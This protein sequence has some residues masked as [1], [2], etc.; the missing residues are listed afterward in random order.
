ME[1]ESPRNFAWMIQSINQELED[2]GNWIRICDMFRCNRCLLL[3]TKWA[4]FCWKYFSGVTVLAV[5]CN[6]CVVQAFH[7][8]NLPIHTGN[9]PLPRSAHMRF[10]CNNYVLTKQTEEK[11]FCPYNILHCLS[12]VTILA[13]RCDYFVCQMWP[14]CLSDVTILAVKMTVLAVKCDCFGCHMWLFWLS[15]MTIL[16]VSSAASLLTYIPYYHW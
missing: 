16:T 6:Q 3:W 15:D 12:D 4:L 7:R 9:L 13:F 11:T 10:I 2:K 8:G 5:R 14:F 1:Y